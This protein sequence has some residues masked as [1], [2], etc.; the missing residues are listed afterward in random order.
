MIW[1]QPWAWIAAALILGILEVF[2]PGYV[3]LGFAIGAALTGITLWGSGAD[4]AIASSL[5]MLLVCFAVLSLIAWV[6]LRR[7]LGIRKGQVKIIDR[8]INED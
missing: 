1:S 4:S 2:A 6:L 5:P 7:F 8:D 3:F